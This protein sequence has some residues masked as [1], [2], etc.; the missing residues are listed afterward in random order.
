MSKTMTLALLLF[1]APPANEA[2]PPPNIQAPPELTDR[3]DRFSEDRRQ[4]RRQRP[5]VVS[6][7][8][9]GEGFVARFEEMVD[10]YIRVSRPVNGPQLRLLRRR[11]VPRVR[12]PGE[13]GPEAVHRGRHYKVYRLHPRYLIDLEQGWLRTQLGKPVQVQLVRDEAGHV[14][15]GEVK[16]PQ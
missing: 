7:R 12:N 15:V 14:L 1:G 13:M 11:G 5:P 8:N 3:Y 6:R 4:V 2:A 9:M 10:G 16:P